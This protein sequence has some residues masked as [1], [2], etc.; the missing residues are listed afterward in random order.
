MGHKPTPAW[1][2]RRVPS[3]SLRQAGLAKAFEDPVSHS[4]IAIRL[5]FEPMANPELGGPREIEF[6]LFTRL[7]YLAEL[8]GAR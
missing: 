4:E 8:Q 3:Q 2:L 1:W 5:G 7:L 6:G